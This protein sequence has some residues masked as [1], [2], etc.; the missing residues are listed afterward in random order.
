MNYKLYSF[1]TIPST[2]EYAHE[3]IANGAASA[4]A[5]IVADSQTAGRGRYRRTWVSQKGNLYASFIHKTAA[6]D[7]RLSYC[8]AVSVAETLLSFGITP[9]I[10]WPNDVL[11]DGKKISGILIEYVKD[12]VIIGIGINIKSNPAGLG[13][14]TAKINDYKRG[15]TRD[16]VLAVLAEKIDFWTARLE[17]GD[18]AIVRARWMNLAAG[19]NSEIK[20]QGRAATLCEINLDG[21][22]VLRRGNDY[23]LA[24]GDEI[25]M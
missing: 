9:Q 24:L 21:A 3:L 23:I 14:E 25:S 22:L 17:A 15:V 5:V 4:R 20:Y 6:R 16:G 1:D 19:L 18:F 2:Q 10:K 11:V 13:Y 12:F 7:P 8:I